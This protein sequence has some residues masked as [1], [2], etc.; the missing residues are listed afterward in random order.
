M[1][2]YSQAEWTEI[3][4]KTHEGRLIVNGVNVDRKGLVKWLRT[5]TIL[6]ATLEAWGGI[7][8]D[9]I[10]V[11]GKKQFAIKGGEVVLVVDADEPLKFEPVVPAKLDSPMKI[12]FKTWLQDYIECQN[13]R[14]RDDGGRICQME[15]VGCELNGK[16]IINCLN[17]R[18]T[19]EKVYGPFGRL[20]TDRHIEVG[21][22]IMCGTY[23]LGRKEDR[24]DDWE[25]NCCGDHGYRAYFTK[26]FDVMWADDGRYYAYGDRNYFRDIRKEAAS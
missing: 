12:P 7:G 15:I 10:D 19:F 17:A 26:D 11:P 2:T 1:K 5:T 3:Y 23:G 13:F 25:P 8:V 6:S 18:V 22:D 16:R 9:E 20:T 14:V 4:E 24:R 21:R